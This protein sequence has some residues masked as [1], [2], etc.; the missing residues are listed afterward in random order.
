MLDI[1]V[2]GVNGFVGKHVVSE[3]KSRGHRVVGVGFQDSPHPLLKDLLDAYY[4]CDLTDEARVQDIPLGGVSAIL[5]LAGL[6]GVG[7]SFADPAK[8]M[9]INVDV[10]TVLC[11]RLLAEK[12]D[13][14]VVAIS[15]GTV[16]DTSQPMPLTEGSA[17]TG[18]GSPYAM[19]KILMEQELH[20]LRKE[21]LDCVIV[22]PFNHSGPGQEAG[23]LIPDLYQKITKATKTHEPIRVGDL[24]TRRDYTDVRDVARA[25]GGLLT[26]PKLAYDLYNVCSGKSTSGRVIL[27]ILVKATDAKDLKVA[28][29]PGLI[30]PSDPKDLFGS[31]E[32]LRSEI[33][34]QPMIGLEQT[35]TDFVEDRS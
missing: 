30:R 15:S 27:E 32:R 17:L 1:L 16:Y 34:W 24:S 18:K 9:E 26:K 4:A 13:I 7:S 22:R 2:T 21:G 12:L 25:Y 29:D 6:A 23:F 11:R 19:S 14:R 5:S 8:Y 20:L 28:E 10:I 3:L 31:F 35:I 33:G